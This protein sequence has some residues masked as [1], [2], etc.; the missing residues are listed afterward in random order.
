MKN[1]YKWFLIKEKIF[2]YLKTKL[3]N[4]LITIIIN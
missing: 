2:K 1:N 4:A 3:T